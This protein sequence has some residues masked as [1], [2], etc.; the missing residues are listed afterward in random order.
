MQ[1]IAKTSTHRN[2]LT[3][4]TV[5]L[6]FNRDF[7]V[8]SDGVD[9]SGGGSKMSPDSL[10]ARRPP[11]AGG[12]VSLGPPPLCAFIA[13]LV[14]CVDSIICYVPKCGG[15]A[16]CCVMF[17]SLAVKQHACKEICCKYPATLSC[18]T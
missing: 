14:A 7:E 18:M 13:H 4:P 9:A 16:T 10:N 8:G 15:L 1:V 5:M 3:P 11:R 12:L 2:G 17:W 6:H